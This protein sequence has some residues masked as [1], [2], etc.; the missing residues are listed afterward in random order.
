MNGA[1][2]VHIL[3]PSPHIHNRVITVEPGN[4]LSIVNSSCKTQTQNKVL[5][6]W[7]TCDV[8]Y[9][10]KSEEATGS[11]LTWYVDLA[12]VHRSCMCSQ[13]LR[14]RRHVVPLVSL[15][16]V[17][18]HTGE[19]AAL[20]PTPNHV[21]VLIQAACK[22]TGSPEKGHV[23]Q[24]TSLKKQRQDFLYDISLFKCFLTVNGM[25]AIFI[26]IICNREK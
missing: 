2:C 16:V 3:F 6:L 15:Q 10:C 12:V 21:Q 17:G 20:V 7:H 26:F 19:V 8:L 1:L 13:R 9:L 14:Q 5:V 4:I 23:N 18:L 25:E 11:L 24:T 22:E